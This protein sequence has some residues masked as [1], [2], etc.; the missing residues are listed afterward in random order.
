MPWVTHSQGTA[1]PG[2]R[3]MP[4]SQTYPDRCS[5]TLHQFAL[6]CSLLPQPHTPTPQEAAGQTGAEGKP[7]PWY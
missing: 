1:W 4:L 7:V 3:G 5:E 2:L 6:S